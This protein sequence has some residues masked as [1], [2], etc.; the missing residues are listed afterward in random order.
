MELEKAFRDQA[1]VCADLGSPFTARL[2][3]GLAGAILPGTPLADR[4]LSWPGDMSVSG[5]VL[6]LRLA[7]G[8]HALVRL[9]RD[10]DLSDAYADPEIDGARLAAVALGA[11]K[12]NEAFLLDWIESPPQTNEVRRSIVVIAAA[13]MLT[14]RHGLPLILSELGA[15]AG[16]ILIW[17]R[18]VLE[19]GDQRFGPTDPILTLRPN[20]VGPLPDSCQ[21][22]VV[23]RAG[24]DLNPLDPV[25]DKQRLL[26]YIWADQIDRR[27]R[28]EAA[29][30][31]AVRLRPR[32]DRADAVDWLATRLAMQR[33]GHMHLV[34]H[35]IVWQYFPAEKQ[36]AGRA[37]LAAAGARATQ[38]AP[39]A[40]LEMEADGQGPGAG[41]YVTL[42]PGGVRQALGR[43][44]FHGRWID[45]RPPAP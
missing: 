20:W 26:S 40:H 42:W 41:L 44:D 33:M 2:L 29:L 16:L 19:I 32:V 25:T 6:P 23:E 8:L 36:A 30:E 37:L 12:R 14:A 38:D 7:G 35:T 34:Y 43:A 4:L 18:Y 24:V 31:E 28:T 10:G 5:D 15:S 1:K 13:R 17:D 27:E 21:P 11:M 45:W 22:V 39:L 3:D 9:G